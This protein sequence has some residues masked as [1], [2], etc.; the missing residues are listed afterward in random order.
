MGTESMVPLIRELVADW[1]RWTLA[2]R[3]VAV[4]IVVLLVL[5]LWWFS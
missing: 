5:A 3:I 1:K 2:E 4:A